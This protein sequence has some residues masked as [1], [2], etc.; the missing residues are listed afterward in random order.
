MNGGTVMYKK[1]IKSVDHNS[2]FWFATGASEKTPPSFAKELEF[3]YYIF[4]FFCFKKNWLR[5]FTK[6]PFYLIHYFILYIIY[7]PIAFYKVLKIINEHKIEV[8][9]IEAFKQTYVISILLLI[10]T[11]CKLH[12][13]IN[14][15]F[16]AQTT[17]F[18]RYFL[19]KIF[20]KIIKSNSSFDFI[21]EGML[22]YYKSKYH[23]T[24][25]K[26]CILWLADYS[27]EEFTPAKINHDLNKIMFY[28]NIHGLDTF[29]SF[30]DFLKTNKKKLTLDIYSQED[31]SFIS[32]KYSN[33]TYKGLLTSEELKSE[34]KN[35][36]LIYVP[37]YFDKKNEL[38]ALTSLSSKM[39][40]AIYSGVPIL[41]HAPI[42]SANS[43]FVNKFQLGFINDSIYI[44]NFDQVYDYNNRNKISCNQIEY[45]RM[46]CN[47][48]SIKNF[49]K[50]INS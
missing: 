7:S 15:N 41:S 13:S 25:T 38:T 11:D 43:I 21:S 47:N 20:K 18:E 10:F 19:G 24:S 22:D 4:N 30:C 5:I 12:L 2:F 14:D 42:N 32:R 44:Q 17:Y 50:L 46:I 16:S 40:I 33:V 45:S 39:L 36:D 1:L 34:I 3:K 9:W 23:F 29:Y 31:Y 37:M 27:P 6:F 35:Y 49:F 48:D 26:Y 28:G 8:V